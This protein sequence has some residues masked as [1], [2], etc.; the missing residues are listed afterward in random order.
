MK[1][2]SRVNTTP[3]QLGPHTRSTEHTNDNVTYDPP[4]T[5][6]VEPVP[7]AAYIVTGSDLPPDGGYGWV[8]TLAFFMINAHTW[9]VNSVSQDFGGYA[10]LMQETIG[11]GCVP[12]TLSRGSDVSRCNTIRVCLDWWSVDLTVDVHCTG[13]CMVD[14][15][16]WD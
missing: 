8:C 3:Q 4:A 6:L 7:E 9:G 11:L 13:D 10:L 14:A 16:V 15:T 2:R 1:F 5:E 12:V